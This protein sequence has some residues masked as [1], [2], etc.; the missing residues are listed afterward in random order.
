MLWCT[1]SFIRPHAEI[2][3]CIGNVPC[4]HRSFSANFR[5]FFCIRCVK[6]KKQ[7]EK[8]GTQYYMSKENKSPEEKHQKNKIS[9]VCVSVFYVLSRL[10]AFVSVSVIS[11]LVSKPSDS[12]TIFM[13][14]AMFIFKHFRL[15]SLYFGV[16]MNAFCSL[17]E[18]LCIW[19]MHWKD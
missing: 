1:S 8:N 5:S 2:A 17:I 18:W 6:K 4:I 16:H 13:F 15:Q 11:L 7:G 10:F 3:F 19:H 14:V 12:K 9:S